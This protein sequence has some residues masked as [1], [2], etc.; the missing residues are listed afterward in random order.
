MPE[1]SL[2]A[3]TEWHHSPESHDQPW[4]PASETLWDFLVPSMAK[5][6]KDPINFPSSDTHHKTGAHWGAI[7]AAIQWLHGKTPTSSYIKF[8][9]YRYTKQ[10]PTLSSFCISARWYTLSTLMATSRPLI[11]PLQTSPN[12]PR[13]TGWLSRVATSLSTRQSGWRADFLESLTRAL[14]SGPFWE[15]LISRQSSAWYVRNEWH[16]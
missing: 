6:C 3:P 4:R 9:S 12:V 14:I 10:K 16:P 1:R 2:L 11:C 8:L 13:A 15:W 7:A 5:G